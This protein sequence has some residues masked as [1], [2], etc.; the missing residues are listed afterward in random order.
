MKNVQLKNISQAGKIYSVYLGNGTVHN[1]SSHRNANQFI[2][3]TNKFLT[4][5]L[6]NTRE[7]YASVWNKYQTSW[8]YFSHN[9]PTM[10]AEL[11]ATDRLCRTLLMQCDDAFNLIVDRCALTNG[12]YFVFIHL[13]FIIDN[14]QQTVRNLSNISR[15]QSATAELY[16]YDS[17][18]R[19]MQ[20][21]KSELSN[22]G[23]VEAKHLFTMPQHIDMNKEFIPKIP[24]LKIA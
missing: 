19:R 17:L 13:N 12:N 1:F 6:Y 22:Y 4:Q 14:L 10:N 5:R 24:H 18:F 15:K 7:I 8:G 11:R 23:F 20:D 9:K 16:C 2:G 21:L 3:I